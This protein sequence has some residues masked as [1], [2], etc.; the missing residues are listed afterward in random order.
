[1]INAKS[2]RI[3]K[4]TFLHLNS[5]KIFGVCPYRLDKHTWVLSCPKKTTNTLKHYLASGLAFCLA[6]II[7]IQLWQNQNHVPMVVTYE[8]MVP[9]SSGIVYVIIGYTYFEQSDAVIELFNLILRFERN[10]LLDPKG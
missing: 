4:N 7:C 2:K 3:L 1:M 8:G 10:N 5:L 6:I 9:A